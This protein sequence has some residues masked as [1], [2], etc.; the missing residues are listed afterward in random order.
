[1]PDALCD[2]TGSLR[3]SF[4]WNITNQCARLLRVHLCPKVY[5]C[6]WTATP[7]C[8]HK[9][10]RPARHNHGTIHQ[11][12]NSINICSFV[13]SQ[14][15]IPFIP[16]DLTFYQNVGLVLSP[17]HRPI[18]SPVSPTQSL[19]PLI[20]FFAIPAFVPLLCLLLPSSPELLLAAPLPNPAPGSLPGVMKLLPSPV[21]YSEPIEGSTFSPAERD[22]KSAKGTSQTQRPK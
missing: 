20:A 9:L 14:R 13:S 10:L 18:T 22:T 4:R 6:E 3:V 7:N 19:T 1:M 17:F 12:C 21:A 5:L 11:I 15:R 16:R 2:T 8:C